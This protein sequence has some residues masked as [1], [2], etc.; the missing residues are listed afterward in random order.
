M[1]NNVQKSAFLDL[2]AE[3]KV[4]F[5]IGIELGRYIFSARGN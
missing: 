2:F 4:C 3:G 5:S 1:R